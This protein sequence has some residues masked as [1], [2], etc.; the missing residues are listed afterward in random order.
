MN[1]FTEWEVKVFD[2]GHELDGS[3]DL[4]NPVAIFYTMG[5]TLSE[6]KKAAKAFAN[7]N[8]DPTLKVD[9]KYFRRVIQS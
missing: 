6:A 3:P 1:S 7:P 8:D 2:L 9:V 5:D 4:S